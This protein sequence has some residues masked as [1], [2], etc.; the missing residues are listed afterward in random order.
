MISNKIIDNREGQNIRIWNEYVID[1]ILVI[2][3]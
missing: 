3:I 2:Q 1:K